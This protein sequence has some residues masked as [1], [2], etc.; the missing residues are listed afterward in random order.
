MYTIKSFIF[1]IYVSG[2]KICSK[3]FWRC[4]AEGRTW[5]KNIEKLGFIFMYVGQNVSM[6]ADIPGK[7]TEFA[8]P[9][10]VFWKHFCRGLYTLVNNINS[11]LMKQIFQLEETRKLVWKQYKPHLSVSKFNQISCGEESQSYYVPKILISLLFHDKT[12]ESLKTFRDIIKNWNGSTC[13]CRV[14]QSWAELILS[15]NFFLLVQHLWILY[16]SHIKF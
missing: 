5:G 14:C 10:T 3:S 2:A 8:Y 1:T 7:K 4:W 15:L 12:R 9:G 11:G 16:T 13:N 6:Q